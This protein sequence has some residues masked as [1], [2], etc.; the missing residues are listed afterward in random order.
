MT[1]KIKSQ[2]FP[3]LFGTSVANMIIR[4]YHSSEL[5]KYDLIIFGYF[6]LCFVVFDLLRKA[7]K[8]SGLLYIVLF[9]AVMYFT[10]QNIYV[11][12]S[13]LTFSQWFYG[14][15]TKKTLVPEY[16]FVLLF[17]G[18][19]FFAS[20]LYYFTQVIYRAFG[21]MLIIFFPLFI[22]AKRTDEILISDFAIVLFFYLLVLVHNR[23]MK[24]DKS[25]V[26]LLNKSYLAS[27][28]IFVL[29]VTLAVIILPQP[30]IVSKQE[31]N[32]NYFND[33]VTAKAP[34][35][36]SDISNL[37]GSKLSD[38]IIFTVKSDY[39]MYLR[40]QAYDKYDGERWIVDNDDDYLNKIPNDNEN[41]S[42][43]TSYYGYLSLFSILSKLD[44][45]NINFAYPT[46]E[47]KLPQSYSATVK[48]SDSFNAYFLLLPLNTTKI[49]GSYYQKLVHGEYKLLEGNDYVF[50]KEYSFEYFPLNF[51]WR[52]FAQRLDFTSDE[53]LGVLDSYSE[54]LSQSDKEI[55]DR[56]DDIYFETEYV[57]TRFNDYSGVSSDLYALANEI[58]ADCITPYEKAKALEEYFQEENF[59]YQLN[60][61]PDSVDEF[62]FEEKCGACG[63]FATA[64]T[65]MARACG[66]NAR[67]VEGFVVTEKVPDTTNTYIVREY[68]SHAY[69]EVYINGFGWVVFDPTV[70]GYLDYYT[71]QNSVSIFG[72]LTEYRFAILCIVITVVMLFLLKNKISE[73]CFYIRLKFSN[74]NSVILLCY[75]RMVLRLS[76]KIEK[77]LNSFTPSEIYQL[78]KTMEIDTFEFINLFEK[79]CYGNYNLSDDERRFALSQ[80]KI[81]KKSIKHSSMQ[82]LKFK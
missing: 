50:A 49:D 38:E 21:T 53:I 41:Y 55:Q 48:M 22:Y 58:T 54:I 82:N 45:S 7:K 71:S 19:F 18:G 79:C 12:S 47:D 60:V 68:H 5:V 62:V 74:N 80:Y 9:M 31:E 76:K 44:N 72:N 43:N 28:G 30:E 42:I 37:T 27:V 40:R 23:Q 33:M 75:N 39:S 2:I 64:M 70:D 15:Q 67:Y 61:Y 77:D 51:Y 20:I 32:R 4:C 52:N 73:L 59:Q 24:S 34:S 10:L 69:T 57:S 1:E 16:T 3:L 36:F 26:M 78:L 65:L 35:N 17:G 6:F 81:L 11:P 63:D 29:I 25:C 14:A 13:S 8:I 66:L 56:I 46:I